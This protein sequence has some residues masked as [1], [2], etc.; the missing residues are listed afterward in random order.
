MNVVFVV[1]SGSFHIMDTAFKGEV[2]GQQ[3]ELPEDLAT[4][5]VQD[6]AVMLPKDQFDAFGFTPEEIAAYPNSLARMSAPSDFLA[7]F[8]RAVAAQQAYRGG[9]S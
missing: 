9:I 3:I 4:R 7:K 8:T 5:A 2:F 1:I 6:G